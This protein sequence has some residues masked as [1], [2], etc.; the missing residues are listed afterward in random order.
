MQ[1]PRPLK[2]HTK[3]ITGLVLAVIIL[4]SMV[5]AI[6][7][8]HVTNVLEEEVQDR[9]E[10]IFTHVDSIQ[11]YMRDTLRPS[12]YQRL[13]ASFVIEAMSS[14]YMSR[15]IMAPVNNPQKG[16]IYRRVAIEARN[17]DYEANDH[18]RQ[19]IRYFR[20][21]AGLKLWQGYKILDGNRYY[22]MARP[23]R[24]EKSCMY[25]HGTPEQAPAELLERYGQRG[26]GKEAGTVA[27]VDFVGTSVQH[28]VGRLQKTIFIYFTIFATGALLFFFATNALFKVLV[29]N[30]LK[31][32][33]DIFRRNISEV[34]GISQLGKL[35][36][37]DEIEELVDSLE[38]MST[39][40]FEARAQLQ[41][42]TSNL[43]SMVDQRTNALSREMEARRADVHLFVN[44][45][46]SMYNS[47]SRAELWKLALPQICTRFGAR[48]I[49]YICTMASMGS[50]FWPET[51][52][53]A[54]IPENLAAML[55]SGTA[56]VSGSRICV[57]VESGTGIAEGLLCIHWQQEAEAQQQDLDIIQALGRQLGI[58]AENLT[59]I[60]S[61][62]RQMNILE[63]IVEGISDPLALIDANCMALTVNQAARTLTEEL[64]DGRRKDGNILSLFFD[65]ESA[66]CPMQQAIAHGRADIRE[67]CLPGDRTFSL[68]LY[69]VASRT[70]KTDQAVVYVRETTMERRMM[71]QAWHAEKMATVGQLTAG[72]AHEINNPLGVILCYSGLL[73]Q[74]IAA[75]DQLA[76]LDVIERHTRQAQ[77]VLQDLLNFARP[78]AAL[79]G[80]ADA[81]SVAAS[82]REVFSVQAAKKSVRT[83]LECPQ[84]P[85]MVRLGVGE[86]EQ[87]LSNLLINALDAVS[88]GTGEI[89]IT[90]READNNMICIEICD[91]GPGV[92]AEVE[93]HLFDPF[94]STKEVG[95][96]TG[97]GLTVIYGIVTDAAGVIE[98]GRS[99]R[100]GGARFSVLLPAAEPRAIESNQS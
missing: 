66:R 52:E 43:R 63:T 93:S 62:A 87:V 13:P 100:L 64:T 54:D 3:F 18:E 1:I 80:S 16:I 36:Q 47:R 42:Y 53:P 92:A 94:F 26:F 49:S 86:L 39:H 45:L 25:C 30:N 27:G 85:L 9:A 11:H 72:L 69:P 97:L 75:P 32:L 7:Y 28:S 37:G 81:C 78:K 73:R 61:L 19:L 31:R 95:E 57:P 89:F 82:V 5:S 74:R 76:D 84:R 34:D 10:L 56:T 90:V 6:S 79:S 4:G 50:F 91:N 46:E 71:M 60:D 23:V 96:G 22:I 44:L 15:K 68:S 77:R 29:V 14:S 67:V 88:E 8:F 99:T 12:M 21:D 55:T 98:V 38:Q 2:L 24:F 41:N 59:A 35:E 51:A 48:R 20:Q 65:V 70:G 33:H 83:R 17:P 40:L 58:A